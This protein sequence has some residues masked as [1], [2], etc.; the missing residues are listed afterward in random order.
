[1]LQFLDLSM[2]I[3]FLF[4][5]ILILIL[6]LVLILVSLVDFLYDVDYYN[7]ELVM[8]AQLSEEQKNILKQLEE[9]EKDFQ[10]QPI[11]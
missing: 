10:Y 3:R 2:T 4:Y 6:V 5:I 7:K 9:L 8:A 11:S 1:M